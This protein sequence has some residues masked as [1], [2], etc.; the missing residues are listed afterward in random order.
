VYQP[1]GAY[2]REHGIKI[3]TEAL[4]RYEVDGLFFNMFGNPS[5]DYGGNG[6]GPCQC[7]RCKERFKKRFGRALPTRTSDPDYR[8]FMRDSSSE[9]AGM[10]AELIHRLRPGAG[11][12]PART[13]VARQDVP[14]VLVAVRLSHRRQDGVPGAFTGTARMDERDCILVGSHAQLLHII[15]PAEFLDNRSLN[16]SSGVVDITKSWVRIRHCWLIAGPKVGLTVGRSIRRQVRQ[17]CS[18]GGAAVFSRPFVSCRTLA[19]AWQTCFDSLA[20]GLAN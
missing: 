13:F 16:R 5:F 6:M 2:Y 14:Q 15:V 8:A 20:S 18:A 1:N 9:V 4:K 17:I 7:D 3:L 10:F 11:F 12:S 19:G